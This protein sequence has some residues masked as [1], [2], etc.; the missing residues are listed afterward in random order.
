[1]IIECKE[2]EVKILSQ[3]KIF[4]SFQKDFDASK[5]DHFTRTLTQNLY[6]SSKESSKEG[7]QES[8]QEGR[9]EGS[10]ESCKKGRKEGSQEGR[11][12]EV[13][14][15]SHTCKKLPSGSFLHV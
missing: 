13:V 14:L 10:Q 7:S 12:E 15:L 8:G 11:K 9:K 4:A 5:V 6:G 2:R 3:E 1:M